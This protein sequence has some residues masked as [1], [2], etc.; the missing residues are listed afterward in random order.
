MAIN[1][2]ITNKV[3][4]FASAAHAGV[5][6]L[7]DGKPYSEHL[8]QVAEY[9]A[10]FGYLIGPKDGFNQTL[11]ICCAYCH[12]ILEDVRMSYNDLV[13]ATNPA[14]AEVS[15]KLQTP[16]GRNRAERHCTAYYE[17]IASDK[18]ASF[19]KLC[20]RLANVAYSKQTQS[21]MH[22]KYKAEHAHFAA[23]LQPA[24]PEFAPMWAKLEELY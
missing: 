15:Y 2:T 17:G 3:L 13:K 12:D 16:K 9:A 24:Y 14:V 20:D 18:M 7:Y 23:I 11:A 22:A 1:T 19:T 5:N 10:M 21:S 6:Q 4:E 8:H